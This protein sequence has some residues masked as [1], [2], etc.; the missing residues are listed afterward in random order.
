MESTHSP[1][2]FFALFHLG[3]YLACPRLFT[4]LRPLPPSALCFRTVPANLS[5]RSF[6]VFIHLGR[7]QLLRA[8][9]LARSLAGCLAD[10]INPL[11]PAQT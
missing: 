10:L 1:L 5:C 9:L 2:L 3:S 6:S 11:T 4:F 8:A 7:S